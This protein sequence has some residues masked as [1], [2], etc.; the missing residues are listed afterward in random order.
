MVAKFLDHNNIELKQR[1]QRWQRERQK[2]NRFIMA[3]QQLCTSITVCCHSEILLPWQRDETTSPV[4]C[5]R[6]V[7]WDQT[8]QLGEKI[9]PPPPPQKKKKNWRTKCPEQWSGEEKGCRRTFS[10]PSPPL[11]SLRSPILFVPF[12]LPFLAFF[13]TAGSQ[14]TG[15]GRPHASLDEASIGLPLQF[16]RKNYIS[17]F[18]DIVRRV[19]LL[20]CLLNQLRFWRPH[21]H[22]CR[23]LLCPGF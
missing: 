14:A 6:R 22:R 15:G 19:G 23:R 16:S 20:F 17:S 1:R 8:L 4:Y 10:L 12:S 11:S 7:A 13:P 2:S 21:R 5:L 9:L 3:K 18:E